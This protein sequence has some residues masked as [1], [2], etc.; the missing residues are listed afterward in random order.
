MA[1][2]AIPPPTPL[3]FATTVQAQAALDP[4]TMISPALALALLKAQPGAV[5]RAAYDL[6]PR[7]PD[8]LN[9]GDPW[10]SGNAL[11]FVAS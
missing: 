10:I 1:A 3:Q 5:L 7:S 2:P 9:V 4:G 8:G 6:L 11:Q